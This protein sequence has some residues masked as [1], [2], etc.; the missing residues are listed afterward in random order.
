MA[1]SR[2]MPATSWI[3]ASQGKADWHV[4]TDLYFLYAPCV[5]VGTAGTPT[6]LDSS[7]KAYKE[8]QYQQMQRAQQQELLAA[9]QQQQ[10][11]DGAAQ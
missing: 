4:K 6:G 2:P 10:Q 1:R 3:Q 9:Q 8:A 11:A 7:L 5:Q